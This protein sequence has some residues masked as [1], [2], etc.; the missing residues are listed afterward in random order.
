MHTCICSHLRACEQRVQKI[1]YQEGL[2]AGSDEHRQH[3]IGWIKGY[4]AALDTAREAVDAIP[5]PYKVVG[6]HSTYGSW[7]EGKADFKDLAISAIDALR[8]GSLECVWPDECQP[9]CKGCVRMEELLNERRDGY[10][11]TLEWMESIIAS[12]TDRG[13]MMRVADALAEIN[14]LRRDL[15]LPARTDGIIAESMRMAKNL[16]LGKATAGSLAE[17]LA[18]APPDCPVTLSP[19]GVFLVVLNKTA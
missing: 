2:G 16:S 13:D 12:Y 10:A 4:A 9:A 5:A 7:H 19:D 18:T 3:E 1:A 11:E 17:F 14:Y 15:L 6:D 8:K